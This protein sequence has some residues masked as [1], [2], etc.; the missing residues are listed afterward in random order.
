MHVY[1]WLIAGEGAT[2]CQREML[3][4]EVGLWEQAP[5]SHALEQLVG[6]SLESAIPEFKGH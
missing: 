4:V 5:L 2:E 1:A 6:Q 3:A